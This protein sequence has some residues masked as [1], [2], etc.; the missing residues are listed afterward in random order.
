MGG[1]KTPRRSKSRL[2]LKFDRADAH[3]NYSP[4][5]RVVSNCVAAEAHLQQFA[6]RRKETCGSTKF[7]RAKSF[8]F[9]Q[10][11]HAYAR[12]FISFFFCFYSF[13]L[14][15]LFAAR[16]NRRITSI[17]RSF[18]LTAIAR[19]TRDPVIRLQY[20]F[21]SSRVTKFPN[22]EL[23]QSETN[24]LVFTFRAHNSVTSVIAKTVSTCASSDRSRIA[25]RN[26]SKA[27]RDTERASHP[28]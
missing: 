13:Y 11:I 5:H 19:L 12:L 10:R 2:S 3:S 8:V 23:A 24:K 14:F 27:S 18:K 17:F 28:N 21:Q 1:R 22:P 7:C 26:R 15:F 4:I 9:F 25:P 16:C 20:L 6:T